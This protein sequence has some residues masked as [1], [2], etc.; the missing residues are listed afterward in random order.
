MA[1]SEPTDRDAARDPLAATE[2]GP[3][4]SPAPGPAGARPSPAPAPTPALAP[5]LTPEL[6]PTAATDPG[7]VLARAAG[8]G[9]GNSGVSAG[10]PGYR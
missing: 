4:P 1:G 5:T 9:A 3:G 2:L 8:A 10:L 6:A 7:E